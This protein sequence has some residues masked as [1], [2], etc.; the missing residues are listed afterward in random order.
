MEKTLDT[1]E[2]HVRLRRRRNRGDY[3]DFTRD[4]DILKEQLKEKQQRLED[5]TKS[6]RE[7]QKMIQDIEQLEAILGQPSQRTHCKRRRNQKISIRKKRK[8][9]TN[10]DIL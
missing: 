7:W 9:A 2:E 1:T 4:Q 3:I 10:G 5:L 8:S 6:P